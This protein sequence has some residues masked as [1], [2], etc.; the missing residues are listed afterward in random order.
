MPWQSKDHEACRAL[1]CGLCFNDHGQKAARLMGKA[2]EKKDTGAAFVRMMDKHRIIVQDPVKEVVE[3][4]L[5]VEAERRFFESLEKQKK[6]R[7][8]NGKS[9]MYDSKAYP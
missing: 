8:E 2:T 9:I 5:V 6:E 7:I 1:V 3:D 4:K